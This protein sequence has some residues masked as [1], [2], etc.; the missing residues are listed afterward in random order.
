MADNG[1]ITFRSDNIFAGQTGIIDYENA[2]IK[3]VSMITGG[4][5]AEGHNLL[6]DDKTISELNN[7][8]KQRGKIPVQLDHG[9]GISATCGFLTDFRVDGN[10]LRGDLH[11]L[12]SHDETPRLLE[13][14][15][16]M[17]DCFGLSVAFKGPPKGVPVGGGKMAARCEKLLSV[18][19]VT[20]PAANEGLFSV[21]KVDKNVKGMAQENA[22]SNTGGNSYT[23]LEDVVKQ[24]AQLTERFNQQDQFNQQLAEY[25]QGGQQEA[26]EGLTL[27]DLYEATDEQLAQFGLTREEVNSAVEEALANAEAQGE[28]TNQ[29]EAQ[30]TEGQPAGEGAAA[31]A[32]AGATVDASPAGATAMGSLEKRLIRLETRE[33]T[34]ELRRKQ[35][36]EEHE[37]AEIEKKAITL[38]S[39]RDQ[40]IEL[41]ENLKAENDALRVAV[42]TG[43]RPV[44]AGVDNG[45]RMFSANGDG[46]LHEFQIRVKHFM[47]TEKKTEGEAIRMAQKENPGSHQ[48]W[49]ES[50]AKRRV[51]TA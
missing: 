7:C 14:A 51:V 21:P 5:E 8:A 50:L 30:G 39:Q 11:L 48:D 43:T 10:K 28:V 13:R 41:A 6:V 26:Q 27:A 2:V 42:R 24:I 19:L 23:T 46:Q 35:N 9:S 1:E 33:K 17:P 40:A 44:K 49:L 22:G 31:G 25:L 15:E 3:G 20:R 4:I 12:T 38:A 47:E 37:L 45:L 34:I 18:D 16:K 29:G 36:A 32:T